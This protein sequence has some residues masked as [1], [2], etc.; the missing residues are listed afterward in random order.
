V[1]FPGKTGPA[2]LASHEVVLIS[3]IANPERFR[4]L[5]QES[6]W[7]VVRQVCFPDHHV[8]KE[9]ELE[10]ILSEAANLTVVFT[11]KDW[12]KLPSSVK[13]TGKVGALRIGMVVEQE[14]DLLNM[15][16]NAIRDGRR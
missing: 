16:S 3:G 13:Q 1:G 2:D 7:K 11:E 5:A 15:V 9:A 12:V 8:Y 14:E 4:K 10:R 6:G